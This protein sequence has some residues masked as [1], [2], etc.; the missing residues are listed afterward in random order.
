MPLERYNAEVSAGTLKP[1]VEQRAVM[2]KLDMIAAE[3]VRRRSWKAPSR[4]LFARWAKPTDNQVEGVPGLYLW[5]GVGRGKTHLCDLFFDALPI[6]RK[7]RLH[8][9]HFM[10]QIHDDLR[11]LGAV[12]NPLQ[13]IADNWASR[14]RIL[15]LDEIHVNDITDAMLLGVLLSELFNR[16]ITLVTTSN[17]RPEGLYKNGLQRARFLP[18]IAQ[19]VTHT[20]VVEMVGVTDYRL[21]HMQTEPIYL[22]SQFA[23][24]QAMSKIREAMKVHFARLGSD[25]DATVKDIDVNGRKLP[26]LGSSSDLIWFSFDTL[27]NTHR[28][29]QDYIQIAKQYQTI[30]ISDV[31]VMGK[32]Q[33]DAARRFVNLIDEFYDRKT[34]LII[35]AEAEADALYTGERLAF[36]FDRAAS[37]LFEMRGAEYLAAERP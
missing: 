17:V 7:Q 34:K 37:R 32:M 14:V 18:A 15:L 20:D 10:Q 31:P 36:E 2:Q 35:S 25:A 23:N 21:R 16:G 8:F 11:E 30:M 9:H 12:E 1:D 5:G 29:T 19:I 22:V 13:L 26:V 6:E 27:L 4:S 24:G 3:L 33:D 28:S